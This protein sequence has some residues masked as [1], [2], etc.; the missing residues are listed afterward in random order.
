M[1]GSIWSKW[2][3]HIHSPYTHQAN[4]Y[5]ASTIDEFVEKIISAELSLTGITNYFFLKITN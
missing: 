4:E 2:D 3:L 5:G 1:I